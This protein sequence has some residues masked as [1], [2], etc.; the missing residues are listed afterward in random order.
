MVD[1]RGLGLHAA[2]KP[3]APRERACKV[4]SEMISLDSQTPAWRLQQRAQKHRQIWGHTPY[5][6]VNGY[7][8][9]A[10]PTWPLRVC[11]SA[12]CVAARCG[13]TAHA[14]CTAPSLTR[15][16]VTTPNHAPRCHTPLH[17]QRTHAAAAVCALKLSKRDHAQPQPQHTQC[18]LAV[19]DTCNTHNTHCRTVATHTQHTAAA[20]TH[21]PHPP[22]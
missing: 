13:G 22:Q 12:A 11:I 14:P 18:T 1:C 2:A 16:F 5:P 17:N 10:H 3:F 21:H 6:W 4:V 7:V 9:S 15:V 20:V 8:R 19:K